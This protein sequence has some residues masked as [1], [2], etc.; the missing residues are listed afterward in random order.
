MDALLAV[1]EAGVQ[2]HLGVVEEAAL[3]AHRGVLGLAE[4]LEQLRRWRRGAL[5]LAVHAELSGLDEVSFPLQAVDLPGAQAEAD[6]GERH[7]VPPVEALL[8][9]LGRVGGGARVRTLA[10]LGFGKVLE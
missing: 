5:R 6:E 2:E 3:H 1:E 10:D 8:G 4:V 7:Q 9:L